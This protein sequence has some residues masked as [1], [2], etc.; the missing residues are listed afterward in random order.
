AVLVWRRPVPDRPALVHG[1]VALDGDGLLGEFRAVVQAAV[2]R[3][4]DAHGQL[5]D[6]ALVDVADARLQ[7][8]ALRPPVAARRFR[9]AGGVV[10][11]GVVRAAGGEPRD[12]R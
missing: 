8:G 3:H 10:R 4:G 7:H 5:P 11:P 9:V 12:P 6:D 2:G 1:P